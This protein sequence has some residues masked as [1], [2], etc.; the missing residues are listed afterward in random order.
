MPPAVAAQLL[1]AISMTGAQMSPQQAQQLKSQQQ[2]HQNSHHHQS[3]PQSSRH[4]DGLA[5]Y[6]QAQNGNHARRDTEL[7]FGYNY[8]LGHDEDI[9]NEP[10]PA[11]DGDMSLLTDE[12]AKLLSSF[13]ETIETDTFS[14]S[15]GEGLAI[16]SDWQQFDDPAAALDSQSILGSFQQQQQYGMS[17]SAA[18]SSSSNNMPYSDTLSKQD[19]H[20]NS[21][22]QSQSHMFYPATTTHNG[23]EVPREIYEAAATL[24]QDTGSMQ[25][26]HSRRGYHYSRTSNSSQDSAYPPSPSQPPPHHLHSQSISGP[27]HSQA[28]AATAAGMAQRAS[29][30]RR[31]LP[32][33]FEWGTDSSFNNTS[34]YI[35]ASDRD[36]STMLEEQQQAAT[37]DRWFTVSQS[38]ATTAAP[39]RAQT[40][41]PASQQQQ[42]QQPASFGIECQSPKRAIVTTATG[43]DTESDSEA[44][45]PPATKRRKSMHTRDDATPN[46]LTSSA[47]ASE[48]PTK[49]RA[50]NG[51]SSGPA[52]SSKSGSTPT[53]SAP[54]PGSGPGAPLS[55]TTKP[56]KQ[57][58]S[59]STPATNNNTTGG[60]QSSKPP[61][62]NLTDQ[63][64]R[65]N[66]IFSEQRRRTAIKVGFEE[67][68]EMVPGIKGGGFSK[69][70]VLNIS[71]SWLQDLLDGN[72]R[73]EEQLHLASSSSGIDL[74]KAEAE[75]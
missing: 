17:F 71:C 5:Q 16:P 45:Q 59:T 21:A 20:Q 18:D 30:S 70:A 6:S 35:P 49:T 46:A 32:M 14:S 22:S 25:Q 75:S 4:H 66:H 23:L 15:W 11:P 24:V 29:I 8:D 27:S 44:I 13:F 56:R 12:D 67:L 61:R 42:Q 41:Q 54:V 73:L 34:G 39:T 64:K 51:S 10:P 47:T 9:L 50:K 38:G 57:R 69:S 43:E 1:S 72:K 19:Y 2:Q 28:A 58:T 3:H 65:E 55:S 68:T 74:A 7:P 40:P 48:K 31:S 62:K 26:P 60:P 52:R 37:I 53:D 63:Q 33:S 36:A